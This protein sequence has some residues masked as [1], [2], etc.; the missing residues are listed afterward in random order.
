MKGI[1][2]YINRLSVGQK[3]M[4]LIIVELIGFSLVTANAVNQAKSAFLANMSHELRTPMNVVLGY[5]E[6][7]MEEAED[8]GQDEFIPDLKMINQAGSHLLALIND[9]LDLAKIESGKLQAY[10]ETFDVGG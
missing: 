9:V 7:L 3:V 6:M 2:D 8:A 5:S 4:S 10:A 1:V